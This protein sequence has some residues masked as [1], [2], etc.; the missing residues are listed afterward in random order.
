[1]PSP[2]ATRLVERREPVSS[3]ERGAQGFLQG[4]PRSRPHHLDHFARE[5]GRVHA[6]N[7]GE[8]NTRALCWNSVQA[9]RKVDR[10]HH[11]TDE[12][13]YH[14]QYWSTG[15]PETQSSSLARAAQ[16]MVPRIPSINLRHTDNAT[17][18]PVLGWT[19]R[20]PKQARIA[21]LP[22]ELEGHF[23]PVKLSCSSDGEI[24]V[25][26]RSQDKTPAKAVSSLGQA[27]PF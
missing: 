11:R 3:R 27:T 4:R 6:R 13:C 7:E 20:Q 2:G 12:P 17:M 8:S 24:T 23:T 21:T 5:P 26:A 16:S 15:S 14:A 10:G 1:M 25:R 22:H 19:Q 9:S 18:S